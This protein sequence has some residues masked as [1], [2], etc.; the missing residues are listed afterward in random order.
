LDQLVRAQGPLPVGLACELM[1]QAAV[2]LQYAFEM[3]MVHRDIKP[4]NLLVQR[5]TATG[6]LQS[7]VLKILDFGLARLYQPSD[8]AG[9]G[10]GTILIASNT[11]MGTPDY[12][13]PEQARNLHETDIR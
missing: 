13:S 5:A 1:R 10:P 4:A 2:G 9:K 6:P 8:T 7:P 3:G 11:V 12:L